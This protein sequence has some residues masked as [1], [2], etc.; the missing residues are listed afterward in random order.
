MTNND[1]DHGFALSHEARDLGAVNHL[2][3]CS[4]GLPQ[5]SVVK[6]A[7]APHDAHGRPATITGKGELPSASARVDADSLGLLPG[8]QLG[9]QPHLVED[10]NRSRRQTVAARLVPGKVAPLTYDH[11]AASGRQQVR[12][13]GARRAAANDHDIRLRRH[14]TS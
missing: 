6:V 12:S 1:T 7:S 8:S 3:A 5:Y 11:R 14:V 9:P 13:G 4:P 10:A 2:S